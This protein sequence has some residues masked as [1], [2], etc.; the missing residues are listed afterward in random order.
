MRIVA[1]QTHP[2]QYW[3]P[4]YREIQNRGVDVTAIYGSDFS[5]AGYED[6]GF[7]VSL[8]WETDLLSGYDARFLSRVG[9]GGAQTVNEV[10]VGGLRSALKQINT[11]FVLLPGYSPSFYWKAA[12]QS[13]QM[14][15][16]ILFRS[17]TTDHAIDRGPLKCILRDFALGRFYAQCEKLLYIGERSLEHY[18]R[19]GV[20]EEKL[21]FS[22]YCVD[23]SPFQPSE[24][25]REECWEEARA[26]MSLPED[27]FVFLFSGKLVSWKGPGL[28]LEAIRRLP[29]D[30]RRRVGV[31][32]LG[33]GDMRDSLSAENIEGVP[34]RFPGFKGQHQL[35]RY[36][37]AA[38]ALVLPSLAT[39][40]WGLVVNEALHHGLP[41]VVSEGVGS[42]PDLVIPEETGEV[43][44][45]GSVESLKRALMRLLRWHDRS[46][47]VRERCREHV[48]QYSLGRAADGVV[49]AVESAIT[50]SHSVYTA[51]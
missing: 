15:K 44:E 50:G 5:V 45:T 13:L 43:C 49:K 37:H 12:L 46:R 7:G 42:G 1:I 19:L 26:E 48:S 40:T 6:E 4:L 41:C 27:R 23:L 39:E 3:A 10:S 2:I 47:A 21:L 31:V 38:D 16:R 34:V 30:L 11:D 8:S 51:E 9:D 20:S 33:D 28:L 14:G 18:R 17:E 24:E 32:F 35:S 22:P 36:Y 29:G 25:S